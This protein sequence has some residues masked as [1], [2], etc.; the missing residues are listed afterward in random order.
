MFCSM[1]WLVDVTNLIGDARRNLLLFPRR[2]F[3]T[4]FPPFQYSRSPSYWL[5]GIE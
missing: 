5:N 4:P 1:E 3:E 2:L